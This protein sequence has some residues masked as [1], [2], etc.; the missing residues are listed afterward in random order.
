MSPKWPGKPLASFGWLVA[1]FSAVHV[2]LTSIVFFEPSLLVFND[3]E[4]PLAFAFMFTLPIMLTYLW[5]HFGRRKFFY[6]KGR[7][8]SKE[9]VTFAFQAFG[10]A[11]A[12]VFVSG[13]YVFAPEIAA[14]KGSMTPAVIG[15]TILGPFGL[16]YLWYHFERG[17]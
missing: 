2:T 14:Y 12:Y 1:I 15:I 5:H 10:G 13:T 6:R 3:N 16:I 11:L 8:G 7:R 9:K 4:W 17:N